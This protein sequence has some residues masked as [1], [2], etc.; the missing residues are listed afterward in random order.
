LR[1]AAVALCVTACATAP[2]PPPQVDPWPAAREFVAA[3]PQV[4]QDKWGRLTQERQDE[5]VRT[6][7]PFLLRWKAG[8]S[9]ALAVVLGTFSALWNDENDPAP[10]HCSV[11]DRIYCY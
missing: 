11:W 8:D 5:I 9:R 10:V 3:L 6:A 2:P 1:L 7:T 4:G